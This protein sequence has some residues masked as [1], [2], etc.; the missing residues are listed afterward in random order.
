MRCQFINQMAMCKECGREFGQQDSMEQHYS[1]KHAKQPAA[2]SVPKKPKKKALI[3]LVVIAIILAS[4]YFMFFSNGDKGAKPIISAEDA[5]YRINLDEVPKR[6]I[7]WHPQ[8]TI[9]INGKQQQIPHNL[10]I[11]GSVHYPVHTHDDIPVLHYET[12]RP[13]AETVTLGYFFNTVWHKRFDRNCIFDYCNGP[14]GN[15]T[16]T[17][18]GKPNFKFDNYIP[19]DKDDIRIEFG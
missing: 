9:I 1:A 16:M 18:N 15:L 6:P 10:G 13:T 11:G 3:A 5:D 7:H 19:K 12:D 2:G 17:V 4:V 8:L 14:E